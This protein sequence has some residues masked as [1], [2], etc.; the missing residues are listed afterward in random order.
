MWEI[1]QLLELGNHLWAAFLAFLHTG[2]Y[3]VSTLTKIVQK[4]STLW[5][6]KSTLICI[7]DT[8]TLFFEIFLFFKKKI[9]PTLLYRK[10][11]PHLCS[12]LYGQVF[13]GAALAHLNRRRKGS[14][15]FCWPAFCRY[16]LIGFKPD[17]VCRLISRVRIL[18]G[19]SYAG[20]TIAYYGQVTRGFLVE[21]L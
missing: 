13:F 4:V 8:K 19:K 1:F 11:L 14:Y 10:S 3:L 7:L 12:G 9:F 2:H 6:V 18:I 15:K 16:I 17:S 5:L 20:K 21:S